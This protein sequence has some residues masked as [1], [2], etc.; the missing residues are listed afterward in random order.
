MSD[1]KH[2]LMPSKSTVGT[3]LGATLAFVVIVFAPR[4][5]ITFTDIE[6]VAITALFGVLA[7]YVPKSGRVPKTEDTP[8][9]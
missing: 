3:G 8:D 2:G 1:E 9:A 6:S 4:F 5:G 7:G